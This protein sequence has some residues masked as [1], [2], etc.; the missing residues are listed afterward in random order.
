MKIDPETGFL[1]GPTCPSAQSVNVAA[2]FAPAVE[3]LEHRPDE[4]DL[5][6]DPYVSSL[7]STGESSGANG[8]SG[9]GSF[10][11]LEQVSDRRLAAPHRDSSYLDGET[12]TAASPKRHQPTQ[13]VVNQRG[14]AMLVSGP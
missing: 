1:A 9:D 12:Q 4:P 3:C 6:Y 7:E 10:N 11:Q 2:Q 8:D 14:R 13:T 5:L